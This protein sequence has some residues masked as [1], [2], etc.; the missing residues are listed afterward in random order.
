MRAAF[1]APRWPGHQKDSIYLGVSRPEAYLEG[2]LNE[3]A[4]IGAHRSFFGWYDLDWETSV[5]EADLAAGRLP[6]V[7]FKPPHQGTGSWLE[8]ASGERDDDLRRRAE[9]YAGV[10]GPV[11]VS[12]HHE[13]VG[14]P[15]GTPEQF[16]AAFSH[17]HDVM[18]EVTGLESVAFAPVLSDWAFNPRNANGQPLDYLAPPVL[19]RSAFVGIDLYQDASEETFEDRVPRVAAVLADAGR[20][21]LMIGIG[22]TGCSDRLPGLSAVQWWDSSWRWA[23]DNTDVLGVVCYFD[24]QRNS[25]AGTYWPLDESAAKE[26]AFS[27]AL[28]S[29]ATCRLS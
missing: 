14:D 21:D 28:S 15:S 11:I 25:K 13:P 17:A 19:Q 4:D 1:N 20:S 16:V 12:F 29:R 26:A 6:W 10:A 27:A 23:V 2:A 5:I 3:L 22:E 7:S 8:V 9:A 24:S 18:S